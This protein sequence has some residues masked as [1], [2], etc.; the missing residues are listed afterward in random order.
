MDEKILPNRN[1]FC[2]NNR[3]PL[4][5]NCTRADFPAKNYKDT[6]CL[7]TAWFGF[8]K[9]GEDAKCHYQKEKVKQ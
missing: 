9:Q 1:T 4:R 5:E 8:T 2:T 6:N 7:S 3:C